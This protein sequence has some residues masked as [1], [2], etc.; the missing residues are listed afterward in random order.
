MGAPLL[1]VPID[2]THAQSGLKQPTDSPIRWVIPPIARSETDRRDPWA[3]A[4][5]AIVDALNG[6]VPSDV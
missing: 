6:S 4:S 1:A 2:V 5:E 3:N